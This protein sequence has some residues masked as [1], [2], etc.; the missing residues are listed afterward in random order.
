MQAGPGRAL[1]P[2]TQPCGR[3]AVPPPDSA[4]PIVRAIPPRLS[5]DHPPAP[6]GLPRRRT[7]AGRAT[8]LRH[9]NH[10][11]NRPAPRSSQPL[12]AAP[13]PRRVIPRQP[14][15]HRPDRAPR[16]TQRAH[17][18]NP[19]RPA[20]T[21]PR[22]GPSLAVASPLS[23]R[24]RPGGQSP[25]HHSNHRPIR[26]P[27]PAQRTRTANPRRPSIPITTAPDRDTTHPEPPSPRR[28][29]Y[30]KMNAPHQPLE[31]TENSPLSHRGTHPPQLCA[32]NILGG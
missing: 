7:L 24:P 25:R 6:T 15:N 3:N 14:L 30:Q 20:P 13:S 9:P 4:R 17:T 22:H 19:D 11:P 31:K 27:C 5:P 23:R 1:S 32:A 16:P 8:P 29:S 10:R 21:G 18:A 12:V 28:I 2:Q 26:A